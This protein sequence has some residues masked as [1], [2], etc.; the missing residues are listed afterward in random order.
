MMILT[1]GREPLESLIDNLGKKKCKSDASLIFSFQRI[2]QSGK[3][4][5][6]SQ[7]VE[8]IFGKKR[9]VSANLSQSIELPRIKHFQGSL[10]LYKPSEIS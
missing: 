2:L 8:T 9:S 1:R 7:W 3:L 5:F 6:Y 10:A 4:K